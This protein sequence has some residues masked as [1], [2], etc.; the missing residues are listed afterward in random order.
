[1]SQ[2][3]KI[4]ESDLQLTKTRMKRLSVLA[5]RQGFLDLKT[6]K[7]LATALE[8]AKLGQVCFN[9]KHESSI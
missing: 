3:Q 6:G 2:T 4:S 8:K 5:A 1:M 7:R 9:S